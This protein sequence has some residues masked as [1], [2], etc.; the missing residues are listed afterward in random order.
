MELKAGKIMCLRTKKHGEGQVSAF[1][2]EI[3]DINNDSYKWPN[4]QNAL[5]KQNWNR[6]P[7]LQ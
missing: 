1:N 6:P 4:L 7:L 3:K 5:K 2:P